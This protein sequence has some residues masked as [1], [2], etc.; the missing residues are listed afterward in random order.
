M[1]SSFLSIAGGFIPV[2]DELENIIRV[3]LLRL[4]LFDRKLG[5]DVDDSVTFC[6][7]LLEGEGIDSVLFLLMLLKKEVL[8]GVL[9][10][11]LA[12]LET[13]EGMEGKQSVLLC[14]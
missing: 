12:L 7:T 5:E 8:I 11:R 6:P 4:T 10:L 9:L 2:P 1:H 14:L 3:E 13:G